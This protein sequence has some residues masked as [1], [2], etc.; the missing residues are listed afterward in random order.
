MYLRY[1]SIM[2]S[3]SCAAA[4]VTVACSAPHT[5]STRPQAAAQQTTN[6]PAPAAEMDHHRPGD[7]VAIHGMAL[8]GR[9]QHFVAHIPMFTRPHDEQ[10]IMQV[11]LTRNAGDPVAFDFSNTGFSLKPTSELSLDDIVLQGKQQSELTSPT[12]KP[13][14]FTANIHRGNFEHG[15]PVVEGL[16]DVRVTVDRIL[17]ARRLPGSDDIAPDVQEYFLVGG[18]DD[19]YAI[20][21]IRA[22]RGVQQILK[23][24]AID[25]LPPATSASEDPVPR[26]LVQAPTRL[27][28]GRFVAQLMNASAE[29]RVALTVDAELWCLMAPDFF[30][31]CQ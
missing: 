27:N 12:D 10:L 13:A 22:S 30:K 3:I 25:N 4:L 23:V 2:F 26:I 29:A 16:A 19:L 14:S 18:G 21:Y 7:R 24:S 31:P 28:P 20:N 8:F 17:V 15:A 11:T 9:Q 1:R 5:T 6:D